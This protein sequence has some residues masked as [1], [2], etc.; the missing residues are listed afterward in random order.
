MGG[1]TER[2]PGIGARGLIGLALFLLV[3]VSC[4][5]DGAGEQAD[6][7]GTSDVTEASATGSGVACYRSATESLTAVFL[8]D[9]ERASARTISP[10]GAG[11][12]LERT[13]SDP[14]TAACGTPEPYGGG[15]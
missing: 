15:R 7:G 14:I 12:D 2:A 9:G 6:P 10:D 1:G 11:D 13:G 5:D 4:T 3:A 8:A